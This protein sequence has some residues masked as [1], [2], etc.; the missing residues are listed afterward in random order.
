MTLELRSRMLTDPYS[1]APTILL[2]GSGKST[3]ANTLFEEEEK[4]ITSDDLDSCTKICQ[5]ALI[6]L[7]DKKYNVVDTPGIFDT[8]KPNDD[9]MKE[10]V[11]SIVQSCN[12]I[13]AILYVMANAKSL[14]HSYVREKEL[15]EIEARETKQRE[16]EQIR[17]KR[18]AGTKT[19]KAEF[20]TRGI[21]I[22]HSDDKTITQYQRIDYLKAD[23]S[24]VNTIFAEDVRAFVTEIL[25]LDGKKLT[26]VIPHRVTK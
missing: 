26:S 16:K 17:L 4:F 8:N 3:L 10:I 7:D 23:G 18:E 5:S 22:A 9:I 12:G 11:Q 1:K 20:E 19:A 24:E 14:Y 13:V 2:I 6:K 25:L 21:R 15:Q